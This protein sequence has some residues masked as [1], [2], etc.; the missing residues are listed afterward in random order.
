MNL[1]FPFSPLVDLLCYTGTGM[2][3]PTAHAAY[4]TKLWDITI[5]E[6]IG[7]GPFVFKSYAPEDNEAKLWGNPNYWRGAPYI[8]NV[9][10]SYITD[11]DTRNTALLDGTVDFLPSPHHTYMDQFKADPNIETKEGPGTIVIQ[12]LGLSTINIQKP[13]RQAITYALNYTY[14]IEEL[15]GGYGTRLTG[16]IPEG[17][18]YYNGDIDYPT[19]DIA[20]ARQILID[21]GLAP[22]AA[23][24]W[25]D[26]QW[27]DK[28]ASTTPVASINYTYNIGNRM[29]EQMM[30]LLTDN[31]EMI[32]IKV[33]DAG[34]DWS[35]FLTK[36]FA[37]WN[38]LE[39][40]FL[41]WGPDF[42]NP[43]TYTIP[44]WD[45][46][47]FAASHGLNESEITTAIYDAL[48]STDDTEIQAIYDEMVD[49]LVND[50]APWAFCYQGYNLDAWD[51]T[52]DGCEGNFMG[53]LYLYP[54]HEDDSGWTPGVEASAAQR[55]TPTTIPGFPLEIMG[56]F[57][58]LAMLGVVVLIRKKVRA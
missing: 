31:C 44:L 41:G 38:E 6:V 25:T 28:A 5:D 34:T 39:A 17:M 58:A 32:G 3:S 20:Q 46:N 8:T 37:N 47:S 36:A 53:N 22:A 29:R 56:I 45:P 9:T 33:E 19:T 23:S 24:S 49:K 57:T 30:T 15:L 14:I 11:T 51:E 12:Y 1:N 50:Y 26:Q 18:K 42:N 13:V 16:P 52:W 35:S 43:A 21:A 10:Y 55:I 2:V 27:K 54:M 40:Y 48:L 7:T 4:A